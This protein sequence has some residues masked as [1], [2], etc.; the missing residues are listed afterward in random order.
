MRFKSSI[1]LLH[2]FQGIRDQTGHSSQVGKTGI[3]KRNPIEIA[4]T[5]LQIIALC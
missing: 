1:T 5:Q 3:K 2:R 4:E